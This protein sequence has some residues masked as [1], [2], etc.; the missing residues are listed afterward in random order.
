MPAQ[1]RARFSRT[2]SVVS[3]SARRASRTLAA[4]ESVNGRLSFSSRVANR[5][6]TFSPGDKAPELIANLEEKLK[7][8]LTDSEAARV[9]DAR[10][11]LRDSTESILNDLSRDWAG[12][13]GLSADDCLEIIGEHGI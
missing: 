2:D 12:I 4:S 7:R 13:S 9:R 10:R 1:S 6:G 11:A 8:R 3:R 5:S